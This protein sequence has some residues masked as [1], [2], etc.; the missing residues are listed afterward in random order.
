MKYLIVTANLF[1]EIETERIEER[2]RVDHLIETEQINGEDRSRSQTNMKSTNQIF[3]EMFEHLD[4]L[5]IKSC[6]IFKVNVGLRESNPDAY[7]PKMVSIGP[8]HEENHQLRPMEKYKLLFLRRF[9]Q[10]KRGLDVESCMSELG[11]RK[12]EALK[13]YDNIVDLYNDTTR[14]DQFLRML[15]L[16]GCFVVEFIRE[17]AK[18]VTTG[19]PEGEHYIINVDCMVNQ[20]L[21]DLLLLENQLPFFVLTMLDDLTKQVNEFP[22]RQLV[23]FAFVD[24]LPKVTPASITELHQAENFKH[25]LHIVH[26]LCHPLEKKSTSRLTGKSSSKSRWFNCSPANRSK[27]KSKAK[28]ARDSFITWH[29][30]MPN[31]T[32]LSEAGVSFEKV[33]HIYRA[34]DE[35]SAED[36]TS[37]FDIKFEDGVMKIP[38]FHVNDFTET[39]LRNLIAYEQ[40]TSDVRS[41]YFTDFAI[42]MDYLIDTDKDVSLL[43]LN[44]IIR[45]RI[46]ED[47]EVASLFNKLAKGVVNLDEVFYYEEE[48]K[49]ANQYCQKP[50]NRM[51]A[52]LLRNYFDSP[53]TGASTVAAII[54]LILTAMQTVLAFTGCVKK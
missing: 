37:L 25:L 21:R 8:Y 52:S 32:E 44:E 14:T 54:L 20:I 39:L 24:T 49:K 6:T 10:R 41:R 16:D 17:R 31:A 40:Q 22:L 18:K 26:T 28:E 53:W 34:M 2:R 46:G 23:R 45:S 47:K 33:G 9:L 13:C 1:K 4:N 7:T 15:L 30:V 42:F 12:E 38:S 11:K 48:T 43:R 50:W 29:K 3:D 36:S 5:S 27:E 35:D 51:K 19:V